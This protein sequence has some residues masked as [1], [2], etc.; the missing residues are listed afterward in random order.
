MGLSVSTAAPFHLSPMPQAEISTYKVNLIMFIP[1][2]KPLD[3]IPW[4]TDKANLCEMHTS[5]G[6]LSGSQDLSFR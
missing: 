3:G 4:S 1:C 6:Y 5:F 2:V